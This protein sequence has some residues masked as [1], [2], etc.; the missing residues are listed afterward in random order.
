MLVQSIQDIY[1]CQQ[2]AEKGGFGGVQAL[3]ERCVI[4]TEI[5][6]LYKRS[7]NKI[8]LANRKNITQ[9]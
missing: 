3:D 1:E 4:P 5:Q 7:V 8:S 9:K 2:M 6:R